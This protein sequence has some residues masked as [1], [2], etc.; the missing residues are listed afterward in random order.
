MFFA[1]DPPQLVAENVYIGSY[2]SAQNDAA[3]TRMGISGIIN[4]SCMG[5][6]TK[7]PR[8][9]L[10]MDDTDINTQNAPAMMAQLSKGIRVLSARQSPV[11]VH[12]AAGINRSAT[13]IALYLVSAGWTPDQAIAALEQANKKRGVPLLTNQSF[14]RLIYAYHRELTKIAAC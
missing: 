1:V 12:C 6:G 10:D 7:I 9:N 3:L 8:L 14:R 4:M 5:Y 13:L 2:A 11:L